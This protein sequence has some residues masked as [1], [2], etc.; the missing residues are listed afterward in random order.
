MMEIAESIYYTCRYLSDT[1]LLR[2]NC[3]EDITY[4]VT[5]KDNVHLKD[6][7]LEIKKE[8]GDFQFFINHECIVSAS[9][10]R[11]NSKRELELSY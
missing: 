3:F 9:V 1:D 11:C 2:I 7:G 8:N 6:Y 10:R 5:S 4:S